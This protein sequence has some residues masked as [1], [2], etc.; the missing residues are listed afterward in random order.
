[1]SSIP[2]KPTSICMDVC[3]VLCLGGLTLLPSVAGAQAALPVTPG[4]A[5]PT[6]LQ[7]QSLLLGY[8]SYVDPQVQAW[9]AANALVGRVGGW[10]AY[11][12]EAAMASSDSD[13]GGPV[14]AEA[15]SGQRHLGED[16]R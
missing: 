2:K 16:R 11:A 7:Y 5:L 6:R 10:R 13:E 4:A 9:R 1:M 8:Q 14:P 12:K 15:H 3:R